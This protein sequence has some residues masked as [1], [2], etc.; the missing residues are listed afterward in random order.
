LNSFQIDAPVLN[1]ASIEIDPSAY[2]NQVH[3][4]LQFLLLLLLL[5]FLLMMLLK[6]EFLRKFAFERIW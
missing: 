6:V 4:L 2:K 3:L 1:L 5:H